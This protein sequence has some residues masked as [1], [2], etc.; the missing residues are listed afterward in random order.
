MRCISKPIFPRSVGLA[1]CYALTVVHVATQVG[2]IM[3]MAQR[4]NNLH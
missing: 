1:K 2:W 3:D 4:L